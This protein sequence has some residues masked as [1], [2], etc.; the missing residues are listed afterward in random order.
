MVRG[1][2]VVTAGARG[3]GIKQAL[4]ISVAGR[5]IGQQLQEMASA[6]VQTAPWQQFS[7]R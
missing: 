5:L 3:K 7:V 4:A 1:A 6:G 2:Q